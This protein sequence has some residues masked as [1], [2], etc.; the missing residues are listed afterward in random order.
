MPPIPPTPI[1]VAILDD[2]QG[3]AEPHFEPLK[4]AF[5][6]TVFRDTLLPYNPPSTPQNVKEQLVD[7]LK[8]YTIISSMR[9]RTPFPADL[10]KQLPNLKLLLTTG[11]RNASIDLQA[12]KSLGIHVTGA[13]GKGRT[14]SVASGGT[15]RG[16]DST[17]QHSVALILGI[18]RGLASDDAEVKNGGWETDLATGLSGKTFATLGLG[19]LGGNV[20][21][22]M[23]QSFGMRILAW[24][25]SLTQETAD[26]QAKAL[27][28]PV[29]EDGEKVFRAVSKEELFKEADVLSVH[30]VLSERSRG[31][32]G[33]ED[34]ALL[35]PTALFVNTSRG[36]LVAED[37]LLDVLEKG[38]IRGAALDVFD[39]EP[40]PK[41]SKW[42]TV[43]W[44]K[45]GRSKVLLSP[46]MGYV[47]ERTMGNWYEEQAEIV[48]RWH[49]GE[50][51]LNVLV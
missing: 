46:H 26:E 7:R 36:P 31:I 11:L 8:P 44:G 14:T 6:I 48:E 12:A 27:G 16:P 24:S 21:K 29:E 15:K 5:S 4:P 22:I 45:E 10:L 9:E 13:L 34:L 40:L 38:K 18:A 20:A 51:L 28:L 47:E 3:I 1:K 35:K 23:Y 25:S 33:A 17:T 30:Y 49:K 42:R 2:Y 39:I 50:E 37:A 19:R 41:E 32:V 43:G